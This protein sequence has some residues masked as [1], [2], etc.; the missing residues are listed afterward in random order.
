MDNA[1]V[2]STYINIHILSVSLSY[3]V[4]VEYQFP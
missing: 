4:V 1:R 2:V 3:P